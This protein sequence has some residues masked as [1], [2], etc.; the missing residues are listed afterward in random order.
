[1]KTHTVLI[2]VATPVQDPEG[3]GV[4]VLVGVLVGVVGDEEGGGVVPPPLPKLFLRLSHFEFGK[5]MWFYTFT[6]Q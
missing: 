2:Q 4:G 5:L 1:M 6:K 3:G